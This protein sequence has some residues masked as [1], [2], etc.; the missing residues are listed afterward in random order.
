MMDGTSSPSRRRAQS[1]KCPLCVSCFLFLGQKH[2][3]PHCLLSFLW[4]TG[5]FH[6]AIV[7]DGSALSPSTLAHDPV[8]YAHNLAAR[9][10][11]PDEPDQNALLVDCLR[12]K[13]AQELVRLTDGPTPKYLTT[14][15]PTVDGI[16]LPNDPA[17]LMDASLFGSYDLMLGLCKVPYYEFSAADERLGIEAVRRDPILRTLVRNLYTHHLQVSPESFIPVSNTPPSLSH[18]VRKSI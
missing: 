7:A 2:M 5:L 6:R 9:V 17:S 15:G 13:S 18:N 10:A 8:T 16:V 3:W 12:K 1:S 4:I 11:C 14:V